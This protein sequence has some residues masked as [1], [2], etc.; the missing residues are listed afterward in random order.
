MPHEG[1]NIK[2]LPQSINV[3]FYNGF[4][5]QSLPTLPSNEP[6]IDPRVMYDRYWC[7][8]WSVAKT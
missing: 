1:S 6:C 4:I 8:M 2:A 5:L 7:G 3:A